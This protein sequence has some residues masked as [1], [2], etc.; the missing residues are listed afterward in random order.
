MGQVHFAFRIRTNLQVIAV[1]A[2]G[3][4]SQTTISNTLIQTL[5]APTMRGRVISIFVMAYSG[6]VP[7]CSSSTSYSCLQQR[8]TCR[9]WVFII[10]QPMSL[11]EQP[12]RQIRVLS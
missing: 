5:V 8:Q 3:M 7:S 11:A 2:F 4:M 10:E 9:L 12:L 1:G 6:G